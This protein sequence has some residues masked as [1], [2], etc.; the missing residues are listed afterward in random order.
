MRKRHWNSNALFS[1]CLLLSG[2]VCSATYE[3]FSKGDTDKQILDYLVDPKRY[4]FR[5]RPKEQTLINVSVVLLSLSSPDESSLEYEVEFL[6]HQVWY[7]PRLIYSDRGRYRYLNGMNHFDRIWTPD[8]YFITHGDFK[9][10]LMPI[11]LALQVSPD[12]KVFH[13]QRR[14]VTLNCEGNLGIFPFD[15]PKCPFSLEST[16]HENS[17]VQ[18][19]WSTSTP[20][21][22]DATSLRK[23]NAYLVKNETGLCDERHTWRGNYSC[24]TVLLVF[25]RD[26]SYYYTAVYVPGTLL[27]TSSFLSFW[28]DINAVPARVMIGVTAMLNFCTTTNSFR[29]TLPVVSDLTAMNLWDGICM[30]FI[31]ASLLEFIAVNY[32]YRN[33]ESPLYNTI[34][35]SLGKCLSQDRYRRRA[36]SDKIVSEVRSPEMEMNS[37]SSVVS[38]QDKEIS[39]FTIPY[40]HPVLA[41]KIDKVSKLLFPGFFFIF[42]FGYFINYAVV[43]TAEEENWDLT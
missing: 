38:E 13:T 18:F 1:F 31:Y 30:F 15:N 16:S 5:V 12:G 4:D 34:Q 26:K 29:S 20:G 10:P 33:K 41:V 22:Q 19:E 3:S 25:T 17:E 9:E 27:V 21:L 39:R 14:E 40:S 23:H 2:Y 42:A 32:L 35:D 8:T 7:D 37:P 36:K 43:Q 24:L 28:L 6:L 11:H